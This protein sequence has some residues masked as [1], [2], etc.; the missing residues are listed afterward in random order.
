MEPAKEYCREMFTGERALFGS[1]NVRIADSIFDHGESPLKESRGVEI[2]G[3]LFRWKYPLWYCSDVTVTDS[4]WFEMAR[5]GVWY[6]DRVS[7]TGCAIEAPKNFRRCRDLRLK[8][9]SFSNAAETLWNCRQVQ[10][11]NVTARGDYFAMN[12]SDI[13][14][15]GLTLYGNYAFDG[16][17]NVEVKNS[18]LLCK[19]AF[20]NCENVTVSHSFISGEYLGWNTRELT[21]I[22]CTVESLQGL[23]YIDRLVIR[24][25]KFLNTTYAFEYSTVDCEIEGKIDS[26]MN[27][28]AGRIRCGAIGCLIL[29]EERIDPQKTRI[30]CPVIESYGK[31]IEA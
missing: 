31:D 24:G 15:D 27:P 12:C 21:L 28:A 22:D 23:C 3:S 16:C 30:L 10:L 8:D 26:V 17:R 11:E 1:R 20:W 13:S 5:A 29:N 6:S 19:D 25:G 14:A 7:V 9:V 18:R 2:A 4:V